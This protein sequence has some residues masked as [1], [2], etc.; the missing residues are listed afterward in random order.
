M[1]T[2]LYNGLRRF[3]FDVNNTVDRTGAGGL[4]G[5]RAFSRCENTVVPGWRQIDAAGTVAAGSSNA[6]RELID[7]EIRAALVVL[8]KLQLVEAQ[9]QLIEKCRRLFHTDDRSIKGLDVVTDS[10]ISPNA[11]GHHQ[12]NSLAGA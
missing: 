1:H 10:G 2:V 12:S 11:C 9:W 8:G 7:V 4:S 3:T 6:L 5:Q